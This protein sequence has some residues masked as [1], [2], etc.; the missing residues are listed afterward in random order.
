MKHQASFLQKASQ[1]I[2][3]SPFSLELWVVS[4]LA[5]IGVRLTIDLI[6][7]GLPQLSFFQFF[8]QWAHLFLFFLFSYLLLLP[9]VQAVGRASFPEAARVLLFGFLLILLA[10]ILDKLIFGSSF[11]WSFYIFDNLSAMPERFFLFFGEKPHLGITYGTRINV[12][13]IL[14]AVFLYGWTKT[15][16]LWR[17][18]GYTFF[19]YV[20][21]FFLGTLPSW[22]SYFILIGEVPLLSITDTRI[23][24]LF[25]SPSTVLFRN[26]SDLRSALGYKM[27][28][29]LLLFNFSLILFYWFRFY[30]ESFQAFFRN[31]RWPQIFC[32]NGIFLLGVVFAFIYSDVVLP[33]DIF[34]LL[35]FVVLL[36]SITAAWLSSIFWNDLY[37]Q[38]IDLE[39]SPHRPLITKTI[40]P[41]RYRFL[42]ILLFLFSLF[43]AALVSFQAAA[44]LIGYQALVTLYSVPPFRLKRFP[45][46]ATL[47]ASFAGVLMLS[48]GYLIFHP[49]HTLE[50]LPLSLILYLLLV[51]AVMLPLK[52]FKDVAGDKKDGVFT[53]PVLL[54]VTRAKLVMSVI[55]FLVFMSSIFVLR[56]PALFL[57]ALLFA[58]MAFWLIHRVG[59]PKSRFQYQDYMGLFVALAFLYGLGLVFFLL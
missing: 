47:I 7:I 22:L 59:S 30:R 24:E 19:A 25:L 49:T 23:A 42:A 36:L 14:L 5:L 35:A 50:G 9:F 54:G 45:G 41:E 13:L 4:F 40:P 53:L 16:G 51:Y 39:T 37:D 31:V 56:A 32:Q 28:L 58:S 11:Y 29:F 43:G 26:I 48:L 10:P 34:S 55:A 18:L 17:S 15:R 38:N 57:W 6:V 3:R 8:Y 44:L 52:D 21:L 33:T 20:L 2:E 12:A 46:I 1:N 27:S